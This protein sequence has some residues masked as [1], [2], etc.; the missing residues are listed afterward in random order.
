MMKVDWDLPID[1]SDEDD[2][3]PLSIK[4]NP[5]KVW[6]TNFYRF[7][8]LIIILILMIPSNFYTDNAA[9]SFEY[10]TG[11]YADRI[12]EASL[13]INGVNEFAVKTHNCIVYLLEN[14]ASSSSVDVYVSASRSTSVS[15]PLSDSVQTISV[16]SDGVDVQCYVEIHIPGGITIP[17]LSFTYL[18][19]SSQYVLLYDYKD[20]SSWM[21]PMIITNLVF[22]ITDSYPNIHFENAHTV[23]SLTV[24]GSYCVCSFEKL[25]IASMTYTVSVGSLSVIQNSMYSQN[26][27][28]VKTPHGTHCVAGATVNTIDTNCPSS[29][30]RDAGFTGTFIDTSTYCKSVLYIWSNSASSCPASGAAAT[31]GQ[32]SFTIT[33]DDGPVQFL[34]DGSTITASVTYTPT[35]DQFSITSQIQL[36]KNKADF[37]SYPSDPRIYLYSTISPK[38]ER[39]WLHSSLKQYI[40]ARPWLLSILSLSVLQP[41]YLRYP[42]IHIP[43]SSCPYLSPTNVKQNTLI[44]Q[45]LSSSVYLDATHLISQAANDTY[46]EYKLTSKGDYVQSEVVFLTGNLFIFLSVIISG[47]ISLLTIILLTIVIIKFKSTLERKYF[48]FLEGN[49]S[50]S[51]TK[52][53]VTGKPKNSSKLSVEKN[54]VRV[55]KILHLGLFSS[56]IVEKIVE[57]DDSEQLISVK[58]RKTQKATVSLFKVPEL[59]IE[60]VRRSRS[61]SFKLFLDS[62]YESTTHFPMWRLTADRY[63]TSISTRLDFLKV[64]YV[65]YWTKEGLIPKELDKEEATLKEYDLTIE[66][67]ADS[68]TNAYSGIAWKNDAEKLKDQESQELENIGRI[69]EPNSV[70][71]FLKTECK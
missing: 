52:K 12:F 10:R 1:E 22:S 67:R 56:K 25:K 43:G 26:S 21:K 54:S 7:T 19:D 24:S 63:F 40:E 49:R 71:D 53:E 47:L 36:T 37:S 35:Y 32:G 41:S 68:T 17:K 66:L 5:N 11:Y 44:S 69:D 48:E 9:K 27:V 39:M 20:G 64:K 30:T 23:S 29:L 70:S 51:K 58:L 55:Q 8:C 38:Y 42:L 31:S 14:T 65:E 4:Y 57:I 60:K 28:I 2:V 13:S 59:Y 34:I 16:Q 46:Y 15:S 6:K 45:K 18:G 62:I 50:L 61:N 33:L 3:Y